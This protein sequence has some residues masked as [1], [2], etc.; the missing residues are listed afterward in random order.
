MSSD[1]DFA[2]EGLLEGVSGE[3]AEA[4]TQLLE[5][6]LAAG[7]GLE[8]VRAAVAEGRLHLMPMEWALSGEERYTPTEVAR[9]SGVDRELLDA[10]WRALGMAASDPDE[11]TQ[12]ADDLAAAERIRAFLNAGLEPAA[13]QETTRVMA[14]AMSQIAAANRQMVG[15]LL[16][17]GSE[18]ADPAETEL[19]VAHRLDALTQTLV[20]MVGPTLE[21]IY[22][23]Q[24]RDQIRHAV[25]GL[26]ADTV[27]EEMAIAFA[28]LV[29]FTKLGEKL[30]AAEF[31]RIS[32]RLGELAAD[33]SSGPVRLV[34]LIGDAAMLA[35]PDPA[36]LL[37]ANLDLVEMADAEGDGFPA[38][39]AGVSLGYVVP[40]AGDFYGRSVNLASRITAAAKPGSVLVTAELR[41]RLGDGFR[42]SNAGRQR[43]KGIKQPANVFRARRLADDSS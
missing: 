43:L 22:K 8:E 36:A 31:G 7:V 13:I 40:R 5:E 9:L 25:V 3:A 21:Y 35:S 17:G 11:S 39:R 27:G 6:L 18:V 29:G 15:A 10:Q 20:P 34:K 14:M 1:I 38:L 16:A 37:G 28:D 24:L 12:T 42:F 2:A 23:L 41:E 33:V 19:A 4:R 26:G 30:P 32:S